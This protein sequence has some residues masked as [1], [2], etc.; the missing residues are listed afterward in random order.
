[1]HASSRRLTLEP[2]DLIMA[3]VLHVFHRCALI[4]L[5]AAVLLVGIGG[6]PAEVICAA[7]GG[8]VAIEIVGLSDCPELA[9]A[10][11]AIPN[12]LSNGCPLGCH[13]API[14]PEIQSNATAHLPSPLGV[15]AMAAIPD[16]QR[17]GLPSVLDSSPRHTLA[18]LRDLRTT[19]I[20][21]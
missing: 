13:D 20:L 1:M 3:P 15:M 2:A 17:V 6:L 10:G 4:Y 9:G 11:C 14:T 7:P 5:L 16:L 12:E 19:V 18:Q 21:L 8:H